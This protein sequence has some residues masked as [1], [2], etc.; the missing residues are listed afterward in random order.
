MM[1]NKFG[2][3][4]CL[5]LLW[6]HFNKK[7]VQALS[8]F[9]VDKFVDFLWAARRFPRMRCAKSVAIKFSSPLSGAETAAY[10]IESASRRDCRAAL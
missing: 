2:A 1:A 3:P 8:T 7:A 10:G 4:W 9:T 6:A 5:V